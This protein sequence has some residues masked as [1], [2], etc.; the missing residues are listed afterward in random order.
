MD[1]KKLVIWRRMM[2]VG[3]RPPRT[4]GRPGSVT[5][6]RSASSALVS[7]DSRLALRW[8]S[9]AASSAFFASLAACRLL[10][11]GQPAAL[12]GREARP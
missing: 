10:D 12:K 11:A 7:V 2:V 5:S 4:T 1:W 8:A 9:R 6:M 3:W